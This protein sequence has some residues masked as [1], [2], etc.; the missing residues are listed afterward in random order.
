M[1][2]KDKKTNYKFFKLRPVQILALGFAALILVG[3]TILTLPISSSS[4][5]YTSFIDALFTATSATCVTGLI[6]VDTGT[7]WS[8]F[9]QIVI[10]LLIQIGGLGFMT[11]STLIAIV[12]GKR[13]SLR[14]RLIMREAY[15]AFDI[16]G[17]VKLVIYVLTITF[18]IEGIGALILSTQFVGDYGLVKG[19]YFGIF[20]SISS[21]CNAGFDLFGNF[22]GYTGYVSNPIVSLTVASLVVL[23]GIG[24]FVIS[25]V[26]GHKKRK[27]YSLHTKVVITT[28]LVLIILGTIMF[29]LFE[30]NNPKTMGELSLFDKVIA[31]IFASVSPRTAGMNTVSLVDMTTASQ[32][33]TVILMFIGASPGSTGGGIKTTTLMI[34]VMTIISI[35]N[36]REDTEI[37]KRRINKYSVYR[38]VAITFISFTLVTGVTMILSI[39]EDGSFM[40]FLYE[41][42]S[43]FGTVGLTLGLTPT[44]SPIGK[45]AIALT[46]YAG[47]LGPLTLV[48][49]FAYKQKNSNTSIKYPEDK[50]IVG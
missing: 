41:T 16:Q 35:I 50:I 17:L 49:A 42:T 26:I 9:G 39:F 32:F 14:E 15:N 23:G 44:L 43:A 34:L 20:H 45:I 21:F 2:I 18:T 5:E 28:T 12:L 24:F 33:L 1:L 40:Q 3:A 31:S 38:A 4:G 36:G 47:R 7:H 11:F 19:I 10:I 6:V 37:F 46:M 8:L 27:K 25:E 13:V 29:F 30:H 48:L 22:N